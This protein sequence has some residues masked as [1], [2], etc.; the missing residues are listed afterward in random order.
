[1]IHTQLSQ[2]NRVSHQ[3]VGG[4]RFQL[5]ILSFQPLPLDRVVING[6]YTAFGCW[7]SVRLQDE[8]QFPR[9]GR[10]RLEL[11]DLENPSKL[12]IARHLVTGVS[13]DHQ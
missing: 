2:R 7:T 5:R 4:R 10:A 1:M 6:R 9:R 13:L 8:K 12:G 11:K 3:A